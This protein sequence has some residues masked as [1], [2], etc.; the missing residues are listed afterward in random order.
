MSVSLRHPFHIHNNWLSRRDLLV[1][2]ITSH[3]IVILAFAYMP[4]MKRSFFGRGNSFASAC[5]ASNWTA[6]YRNGAV[7][8]CTKFNLMIGAYR[9]LHTK[10]MIM[11]MFYSKNH[12]SQWRWHLF[13]WASLI[14]PKHSPTN[15]VC[16][17]IRFQNK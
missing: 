6:Y 14:N 2:F 3:S 5:A 9:T 16:A 11:K 7:L 4:I 15:C 12:L 8:L 1:Y 17:A 10:L 13:W